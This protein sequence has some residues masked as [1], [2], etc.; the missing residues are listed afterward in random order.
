MSE[1]PTPPTNLPQSWLNRNVWLISLSATFADLGYQAVLAIFPLFLVKRLGAPIWLFGLSTA[2][3]YGPGAI[4]GF[5]GGKMGDRWGQKRV[6]IGGNLLIPL[7]SLSGLAVM[8]FQA[9]ALFAGG[10]WARNFRTA[11]RRSMLVEATKP[12]HRFRAFGFLHALDI[13]GGFLAA[14]ITAFLVWNNVSLTTIFL[15]TIIP[16]L[17]SSLVLFF[18]RTGAPGKSHK[19]AEQTKT[20]PP[21][22]M[23][24]DHKSLYFRLLLAT[25][26][27]G[28]SAF[29]FGFPMLTVNQALKSNLMAVLAYVV[30][31]GF[32][33]ITGLMVGRITKNSVRTLALFGYLT[34]GAACAGMAAVWGLHFN[35]LLFYPVVA[36]MGLALGVIETIEPTIISLLVPH[37]KSGGGMGAL[38]AMRSIG[39]FLANIMMG[40][41]YGVQD[42][43]LLPYVYAG[44]VAAVAAF[45]LLSAPPLRHESIN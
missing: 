19:P 8:P 1:L 37:E 13:G 33:A 7:L 31:F 2:I 20:P 30:F 25:A 29:D 44:V 32:S 6:A 28:F 38:T 4:F 35:P 21:P 43:W 3:S 41:L 9:I 15:L 5:M 42:S 23:H 10:W 40:L 17:L 26:L 24:A 12:E 39:L 22:E 16:L 36:L 18:V 27:Y 45:V 11:P 34:G 14:T